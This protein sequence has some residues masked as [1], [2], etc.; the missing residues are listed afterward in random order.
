MKPARKRRSGPAGVKSLPAAGARGNSRAGSRFL[1]A[2][3]G[4]E[5]PRRPPSPP[6]GA[7]RA[8]PEDRIVLIHETHG[9]TQTHRHT[10]ER[11]S[12]CDKPHAPSGERSPAGPPRSTVSPGARRRR[13]PGRPRAGRSPAL[14]TGR[15]LLQ[16]Q[17]RGPGLRRPR[18]LCSTGSCLSAPPYRS[19]SARARRLPDP[20]PRPRLPPRRP[21]GFSGGVPRSWSRRC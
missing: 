20:A 16:L 6:P 19:R 5:S 21:A 4:E 9:R 11:P 10:H 14:P 15:P 12:S 1:L 3:P 2:G 13:S 17:P 7:G 8:F 18:W